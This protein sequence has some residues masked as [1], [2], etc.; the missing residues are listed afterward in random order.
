MELQKLAAYEIDQ[1]MRKVWIEVTTADGYRVG[2]AEM[3]T[4]AGK[5]RIGRD[6]SE[7][8]PLLRYNRNAWW[9]TRFKPCKPK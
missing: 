4:V 3:N 2:L 6:V 7:V 8:P 5:S 9:P 1:R